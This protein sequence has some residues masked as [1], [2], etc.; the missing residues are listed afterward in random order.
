MSIEAAYTR[1][2][3]AMGRPWGKEFATV[4]AA[5]RALALAAHDDACL[6]CLCTFVEPSA[7]YL[8][9]VAVRRARCDKRADIAALAHG[10][11]AT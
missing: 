5:A 8:A 1:F 3:T 2:T 6:Q 9:I 11:E 4:D 10:G 7:E